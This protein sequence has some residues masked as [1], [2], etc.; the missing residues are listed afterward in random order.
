MPDR[1]LVADYPE[2]EQ[3]GELLAF[4]LPSC[5]G[6]REEDFVQGLMDKFT[7]YGP[8]M[9]LSEKQFEWLTSIG[10]RAGGSS[11]ED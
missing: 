5:K 10:R 2:P 9:F 6:S 8:R 7:T 1:K 11:W 4:A 3:F